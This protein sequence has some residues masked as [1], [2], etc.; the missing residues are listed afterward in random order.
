MRILKSIFSIL[1]VV[2]LVLLA[3]S[4]IRIVVSGN[5]NSRLSFYSFFDYLRSLNFDVTPFFREFY[6]SLIDFQEC[7]SIFGSP[8]LYNVT[9]VLVIDKI[10]SAITGFFEGVSKFITGN[11]ILSRRTEY[12]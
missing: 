2:I 11:I 9:G 3:V 6:T 1:L 5:G 7:L 8:T 10:L 4:T 12:R